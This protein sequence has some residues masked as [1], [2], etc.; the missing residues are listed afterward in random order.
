VFNFRDLAGKRTSS[1]PIAPGLLI[2]S[3]A[4]TNVTPSDRARLG[5]LGIRTA[6]DLRENGE[7][8]AEPVDL[9]DLE[10]N[11]LHIPFFDG[12][13][14]AMV[15]DLVAVN[16]WFL[17]ERG[18]HLAAAVHALCDPGALPAVYFCSTGKDRTGILTAVILAALE[19]DDDVIVTDYALTEKLIPEWYFDRAV[20][21]ARAGGFD[22]AL[23]VEYR[24]QS[25]ASPP[26]VMAELLGVLRRDF[27]GATRYLQTN[28]V[29]PDELGALAERLTTPA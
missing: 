25:L 12:E 2:R 21:R 27:G 16:R 15:T 11:Q 1:G 8:A 20:E 22:E 13:T 23:L 14:S 6:L 18:L 4:L 17:R 24:E 29:T 26:S 9:S 3:N 7:R 28:G 5:A 10:I 19:V